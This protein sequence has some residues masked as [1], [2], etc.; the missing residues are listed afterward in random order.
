MAIYKG[1]PF[2]GGMDAPSGSGAQ[3][4][5][6]TSEAICD[7][8]Q[9]ATTP[10]VMLDSTLTQSL[11]W[12][13][14]LLEDS[15]GALSA[16]W[17]NRGLVAADGSSAL[18]WSNRQLDSSGGVPAVDW[19]NR[20][21]INSSSNNVIDWE[22]GQLFDANTSTLLITFTNGLSFFAAAAVAQQTGGA[23]TAG[24]LY[25]ATEQGM[26]NRLYTAMRAYG[27]LT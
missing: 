16:D 1:I 24:V 13:N 4:I 21:L 23:A 15:T 27:L 22:N 19:Q 18:D 26:L 7:W 11:D 9:D 14:R 10:G 12:N 3:H 8:M 25:T 20:Y 2:N 17:N 5:V 6:E